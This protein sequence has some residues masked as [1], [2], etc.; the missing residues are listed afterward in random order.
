MAIRVR[1]TEHN[2][3]KKGKGAFWGT[4]KEAKAGAKKKRRQNDKIAVTH[5]SR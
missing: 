3:A 1:K 4:K 5:A 2:G